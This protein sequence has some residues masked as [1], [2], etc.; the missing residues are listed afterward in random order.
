[1]GNPENPDQIDPDTEVA[2]ASEQSIY[3]KLTDPSNILDSRTAME[4]TLTSALPEHKPGFRPGLK[5]TKHE[6]KRRYRQGV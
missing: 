5:I 1:M 4:I 6:T 3:E 2:E